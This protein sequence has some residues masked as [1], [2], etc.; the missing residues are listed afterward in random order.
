[1]QGKPCDDD[2][3]NDDDPVIGIFQQV[4]IQ[5]Y[6][7]HGQAPMLDEMPPPAIRLLT[8]PANE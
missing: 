7:I 8:T 2:H 3:Q 6:P 5:W 1:M 4:E